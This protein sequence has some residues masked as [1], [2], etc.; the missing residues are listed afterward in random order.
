MTR[1]E[2]YT[3]MDKSI[4]KEKEDPTEGKEKSSKG[5]EDKNLRGGSDFICSIDCK[6]C[7]SS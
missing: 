1:A 3:E 2:R 6:S 7:P 5:G 4:S